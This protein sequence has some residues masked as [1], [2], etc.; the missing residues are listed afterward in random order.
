MHLSD[1]Y[2]MSNILHVLNGDSTAHGFNDTGLDGDVLIWREIF[3]QGPLIENIS[4]AAFWNARSEW[5]SKTYNDTLYPQNV[6]EPLE[7]LNEAYEEINLWFEFDLHC[8]ANLLGVMVMIAQRADLSEQAIYLI[9]PD[10]FPGKPDFRGMGELN[11][12]ELEYLYDNIRLRLTEYDFELAGEAWALYVSGDIAGLEKW[13]NENPFWANMTLLKPALEAHIK[14]SILNGNG[15]NYIE[16]KLL[17]IYNSGKADKNA[18][19]QDFWATEKIYGMGDAEIDLYLQ[20]LIDK[21][22]I[23]L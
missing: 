14:R 16:Q 11:G 2:Q 10:E 15:L 5:I 13:L 18:I 20:K 17:D 9:C 12:E 1:I 7:K 3:S 23:S 22:L 19:Y 8:Q 6:I 4:S 21:N